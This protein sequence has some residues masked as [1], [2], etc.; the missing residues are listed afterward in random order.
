MGK[1]SN[2]GK[3]FETIYISQNETKYLSFCDLAKTT[4]RWYCVL[5]CKFVL[6]ANTLCWPIVDLISQ[7][8]ICWCY[9]IKCFLILF[10]RMNLM[11][12]ADH[13]NYLLL[14]FCPIRFNLSLLF[15]FFTAE[16][17]QFKNLLFIKGDSNPKHFSFFVI[18]F[19]VPNEVSFTSPRLIDFQE[20]SNPPPFIQTTPFI[21]LCIPAL[22]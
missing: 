4:E 9:F 16:C 13:L 1:V 17:M 5:F 10:Y 21:K 2:P 3:L 12:F 14:I 8:N 19:N 15:H 6:K 20:F 18:Y 7:S 11:C 22:Y